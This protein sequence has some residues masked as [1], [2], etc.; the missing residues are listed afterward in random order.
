MV[1]NPNVF[2]HDFVQDNEMHLDLMVNNPN[3]FYLDYVQ[4]N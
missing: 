3:V 4:D 2:Y 1:N